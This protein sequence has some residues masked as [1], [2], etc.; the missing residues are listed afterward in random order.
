MAPQQLEERTEDPGRRRPGR[1]RSE[2]ADRAILDTCIEILGE[3]GYASL[4]I[5][6]VAA[7]AGVGKSTVYRRFPSKAAM[8]TAAAYRIRARE[9]PVPDTGSLRGDL[10]ALVE[11]GSRLLSEGPWGPLIAAVASEALSDREVEVARLRFWRERFDTLAVI[12]NRAVERGEC[13]ADVDTDALLERALGPMFLR[14]LVTG[15]PLDA[16]AAERIVE[17]AIPRVHP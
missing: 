17:E 14:Y 12:V 7:R 5:E 1:P 11:N 15:A 8:V 10:I 2:E 3:V 4:T 9:L 6:A 13:P 16:G